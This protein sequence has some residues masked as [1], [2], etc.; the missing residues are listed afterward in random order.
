MVFLLTETAESGARPESSSGGSALCPRHLTPRLRVSSPEEGSDNASL[1]GLWEEARGGAREVPALASGPLLLPFLPSFPSWKLLW[2]QVEK[3][4]AISLPVLSPSG[5]SY[6]PSSQGHHPSHSPVP[7]CF[8]E[9]LLKKE[10][11]VSTRLLLR[12]TPLGRECLQ[13]FVSIGRHLPTEHRAQQAQCGESVPVSYCCV[14]TAPYPQNSGPVIQ[15]RPGS[16]RQGSLRLSLMVV[17]T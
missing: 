3:W 15:G 14:T 17:V 8:P 11:M 4:A 12:E 10:A 13:R 1:R 9:M 2:I 7:W 16:A 6:R 5:E